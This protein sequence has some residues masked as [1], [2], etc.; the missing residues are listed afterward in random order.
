M[1]IA[2]SL[3][4]LCGS[5]LKYCIY[6]KLFPT[7][8]TDIRNFIYRRI[9][10]QLYKSKAASHWYCKVID[11]YGVLLQD[12]YKC[13]W[14]QGGWWWHDLLFHQPITIPPPWTKCRAQGQYRWEMAVRVTICLGDS[15]PRFVSIG[16]IFMHTM[17][18]QKK[19]A[20]CSGHLVP[21]LAWS[22]SDERG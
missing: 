5:L 9:I 4:H 8:S 16:P 21:L 13:I 12:S 11:Y 17:N 7:P 6:S 19:W 10:E 3:I 14:L 15:I 22:E 2:I 18:Q 20:A 1:R